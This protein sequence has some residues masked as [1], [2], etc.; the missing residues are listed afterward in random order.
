MSDYIRIGHARGP[1]GTGVSGAPGDQTG[2]GR[3]VREDNTKT[4]KNNY[5]LAT[6]N[7]HT[8]LRPI[9]GKYPTLAEDSAKACEAGCA[10]NHIGY[11]QKVVQGKGRTSL[12]DE[13]LKVNFNLSNITVD[14]NTDCSAFMAVCAN[15]GG[16]KISKN[17]WTGDMATAFVASGAYEKKTD[18]IYFSSTDYLRRGDILIKDGHTLMVLDN[19]SKI[20][21]TVTDTQINKDLPVQPD[22]N[23]LAIKFA[24]SVNKITTTEL[25]INTKIMIIEGSKETPLKDKNKLN[26]YNWTCVLSSIMDSFANILAARGW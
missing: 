15:A 5:N 8:L 2:T 25:S 11:S 16:I 3:E 18:A 4:N 20:S 6:R 17:V 19:G 13:A 7:F 9:A 12:Y 23:F 24:T 22:N 26:L 14:C 1:E 10:N 21:T